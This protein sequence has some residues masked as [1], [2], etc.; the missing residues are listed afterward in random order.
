MLPKRE[1]PDEITLGNIPETGAS[2]SYDLNDSDQFRQRF[3]LELSQYS[4]PML[5]NRLWVHAKLLAYLSRVHRFQQ[6]LV[7]LGLS[8]RQ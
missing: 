1:E 5:L 7:Y 6:S 8:G 3:A 2:L 4:L